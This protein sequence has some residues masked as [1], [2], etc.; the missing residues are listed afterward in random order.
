[1]AAAGPWAGGRGEAA[2]RAHRGRAGREQ[3]AAAQRAQAAAAQCHHVHGGWQD[4][5]R[6]QFRQVGGLGRDG[7]G[8]AQGLWRPG[9]SCQSGHREGHGPG[10][11]RGPGPRGPTDEGVIPVDTVNVA[12]QHG[13]RLSPSLG[14]CL[15]RLQGH[16]GAGPR[17]RARG[18]AIHRGDAY[19]IP[20]TRR[21]RGT[22]CLTLMPQACKGQG[23]CGSQQ[24][25]RPELPTPPPLPPIPGLTELLLHVLRQSQHRAPPLP[26]P[27]PRLPR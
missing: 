21:P 4:S 2:Q 13:L 18:T 1:M 20:R 15:Q 12:L 25:V 10:H 3:A 7:H 27:P 6:D 26:A 5:V 9:P 19:C 11:R 14:L 23:G 24:R 16:P 8:W 17:G 22:W